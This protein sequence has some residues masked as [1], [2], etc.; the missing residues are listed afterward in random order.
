MKLRPDYS[1][2]RGRLWDSIAGFFTA[3]LVNTF[4]FILIDSNFDSMYDLKNLDKFLPW[5]INGLFLLVFLVIL[6]RFALGYL[7]AT[8]LMLAFPLLGAGLF[9]AGCLLV[10]AVS[11][12]GDFSTPIEISSI[13][14]FPA[15]CLII[16]G[17]VA[18]IWVLVKL[19]RRT[20]EDS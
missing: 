4:L 17:G 6:P 18:L 15:S 9:L 5:V 20:E 19:Y 11:T 7:L 2:K 13:S 1:S 10:V 3:L 16:I 14:D 8:A 12:L